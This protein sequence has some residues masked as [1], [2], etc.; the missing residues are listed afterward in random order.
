MGTIKSNKRFI[1]SSFVANTELYSSDFA[2]LKEVTLV[3]YQS[4]KKKVHLLSTMHDV[5]N[6]GDDKKKPEVV[7]YYNETKDKNGS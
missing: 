5:G 7:T 1:P 2:F 3:S 4:K 6:V